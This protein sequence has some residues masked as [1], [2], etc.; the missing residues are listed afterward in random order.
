MLV[1]GASL[2]N[3]FVKLWSAM[4]CS[5]VLLLAEVC[6]LVSSM[7]GVAAEL[8]MQYAYSSKG[9]HSQR[10]FTAFLFCF[11]LIYFTAH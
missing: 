1:Q 3:W 11:D 2:T 10:V 4:P 6:D 9:L 7:L 8:T 5:S